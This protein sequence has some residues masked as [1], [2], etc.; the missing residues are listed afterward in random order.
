MR[1]T[2]QQR[3]LTIRASKLVDKAIVVRFAGG[4]EIA[5]TL[6][7]ATDAVLTIDG[8]DGA[9]WTIPLDDGVVAIGNGD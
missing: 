8:N 2:E 3:A 4:G 7:K 1:T 5:G 9:E 6:T